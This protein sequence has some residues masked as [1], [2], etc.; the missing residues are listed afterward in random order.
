MR[1][2]RCDYCG[3]FIEEG[4]EFFDDKQTCG[5][6][7]SLLCCSIEKFNYGIHILNDFEVDNHCAEWEESEE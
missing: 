1:G 4:S 5:I 3:N 6:Y 2:I 7:C